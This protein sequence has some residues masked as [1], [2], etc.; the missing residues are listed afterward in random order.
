MILNYMWKK[1][2]KEVVSKNGDKD[3]KLS[4]FD[5]SKQEILE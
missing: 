5:T 3:F 4:D 2:E 1:L